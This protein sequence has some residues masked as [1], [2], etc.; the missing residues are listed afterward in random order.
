MQCRPAIHTSRGTLGAHN[1][2]VQYQ[3]AESSS[4]AAALKIDHL[5][6]P[7]YFALLQADHMLN[8]FVS[9]SVDSL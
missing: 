1:V 2:L 6:M 3:P 9:K 8:S 4:L 7:S 5:I